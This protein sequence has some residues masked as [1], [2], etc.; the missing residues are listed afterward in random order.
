MLINCLQR[1][2]AKHS[3]MASLSHLHALL[4]SVATSGFVNDE[5]ELFDR[6][7]THR[8]QFVKIL[9]FGAPSEEQRK[10]LQG[11]VLHLAAVSRTNNSF[12]RQDGP[13]QGRVYD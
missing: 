6:L 9:N 1:H 10:E 4:L 8:A 5:Q 12:T 2:H 3:A 13:G 7:T 11:G